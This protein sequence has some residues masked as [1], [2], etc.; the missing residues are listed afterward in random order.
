MASESLKD[1]SGKRVHILGVAGTLMGAFAS[2]LKAHGVEVT[3]SDQNIYPPMSDVLKKAGVEVFAPFSPDNLAKARPDL[4]IVGNVI[5][6]VNVEMEAVTQAGIPYLSLPSAL[7]TMI[8]PRKHPIVVAGTHGKTTTSSMMSWILEELGEKPSFFIGGVTRNFPESFRVTDSKYMVLEGDEYDTAFFDK[9]PKFVHYRPT[10]VILTSV[11]YDHADIYPDINAVIAAFER[12]ADLVSPNGYFVACAEYEVPLRIAHRSRASV[13]TYG[14]G[15]GVDSR[16]SN[17]DLSPAGATFRWSIDKNE[18]KVKL[19]ATG[20][21]NVLNALACLTLVHARGLDVERAIAALATFEGVKRRQ[22]IYGQKGGITLI[23]DFAHHPT[24]VRETISAIRSKYPNSRIIACFEP[25]SA[26]SRRK[27]FQQAYAES[28][29][30]ADV[31]FVTKPYEPPAANP[32]HAPG[33]P[34]APAV[35]STDELLADLTTRGKRARVLATDDGGVKALARDLKSG[36]I[37][38]VMSNGSFD[39]LLPRLL[40]QLPG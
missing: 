13:L 16:A 10:D 39:G 5:R 38:L 31:V 8:L 23:D 19:N 37:V 3:G 4:V 12:L 34:A 33:A 2:F 28:F 17:I 40:Q 30:L 21:H 22:E 1:F 14:L 32:T 36:D 20:R 18:Y 25:R 29:D 11:E 24:A 26:T 9:V 7:E 6:K 35:F 27:V 15:M